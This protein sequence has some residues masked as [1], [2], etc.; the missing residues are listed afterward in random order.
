MKWMKWNEWNEMKWNEMKWNEWNEMNERMNE[1]NE[2][3][4]EWMNEWT[5]KQN[6]R[7]DKINIYIYTVVKK[8]FLSAVSSHQICFIPFFFLKC[9]KKQKMADSET[10]AATSGLDI[11]QT[12][13]DGGDDGAVLFKNKKTKVKKYKKKISFIIDKKYVIRA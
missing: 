1:W 10:T 11:S 5:K 3:A 7:K 4:N 2:W 6:E 8:R 12:P 9:R 13:M